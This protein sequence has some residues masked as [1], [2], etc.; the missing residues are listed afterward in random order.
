[1]NL[2]NLGL[3]KKAGKIVVGRKAIK[4]KKK[5]I[6]LIILAR[7]LSYRSKRDIQIFAEKNGIDIIMGPT[8]SEMGKALGTRP[9]GIVGVCGPYSSLILKK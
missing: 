7:D 4:Y 5:K 8:M 9:V 2:Q 3:L 6:K 1:M